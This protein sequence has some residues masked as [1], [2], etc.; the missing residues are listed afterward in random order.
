MRAPGKDDLLPEE[1]DLHRIGGGDEH[2]GQPREDARAPGDVHWLL[3]PR[4]SVGR[5]E[6]EKEVFPGL[7]G[8]DDCDRALLVDSHG[9]VV[10]VII[11]GLVHAPGSLVST[12]RGD[13]DFLAP[14]DLR[15]VRSPKGERRAQHDRP[16][17]EKAQHRHH[18]PFLLDNKCHSMYWSLSTCQPVRNRSGSPRRCFGLLTV[19]RVRDITSQS[20]WR[21]ASAGN[22]KRRN[23]T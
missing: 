4:L 8:P 20:S 16:Q 6:L 3:E 5:I 15:Q 2:S 22:R 1:I 17:Q 12:G 9:G 11:C 13:R 21:P 18:G 19:C 23:G 14:D 10:D 7:I